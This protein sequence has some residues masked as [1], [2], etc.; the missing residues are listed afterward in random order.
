[1]E[2]EDFKDIVANR[3][4]RARLLLAL[5]QNFLSKQTDVDNADDMTVLVDHWKSEKLVEHEKL[6]GV[7]NRRGGRNGD[8]AFDHDVAERALERSGQQTAGGQNPD[9]TFVGIDREKID[10]ALADTF[11]PDAVERFSHGHIRIEQRKIFARVL[12]YR[13]IEIRNAS[14]LRHSQLLR[15]ERCLCSLE[16]RALR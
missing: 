5:T 8:D 15:D 1:M 9:K 11:T 2:S 3:S 14:G 16:F 7:E 4:G 13:G 6:A 12:G 10:D